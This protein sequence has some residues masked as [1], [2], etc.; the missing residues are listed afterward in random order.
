MSE[1]QNNSDTN[2]KDL[3]V[4]AI[5]KVKDNGNI[6]LS[7]LYV[8][9][10]FDDLTLSIYDDEENLLAQA[11]IDEWAK[12]KEDPE[13]FDENIISSLKNVLSEDEIYNQLDSLDVIRP[14]SVVLVDDDF[15]QK[16][17]LLRL[18]DNVVVLEDEFLKNL[19]KELD[20]FL[21]NLLKD[22]K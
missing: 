15:E 22:V 21:D 6:S 12:L 7:D 13:T 1:I 11:N 2:V 9:V 8:N 18:D 19:D 20:D 5:A 10:G 3:F 17:E 4:E 16:E 14:F